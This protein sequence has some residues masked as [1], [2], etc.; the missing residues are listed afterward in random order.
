MIDHRLSIIAFRIA[1][2]RSGS[3]TDRSV[4][5]IG[6]GRRNGTGWPW[7]TIGSLIREVPL[8]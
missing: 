1:S 7:N 6:S 4:S 8:T 5:S 2:N 3:V